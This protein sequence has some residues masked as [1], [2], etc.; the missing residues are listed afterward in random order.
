MTEQ[1]T[2]I[3]LYTSSEMEPVDLKVNGFSKKWKEQ[4]NLH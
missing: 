2:R 3:Q 1:L 4:M